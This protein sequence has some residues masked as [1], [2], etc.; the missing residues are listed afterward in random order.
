MNTMLHY[1]ILRGQWLFAAMGAGVVLI[2]AT[3]ATYLA[4][5]RPRDAALRPENGKKSAA[6]FSFLDA[7]P[8]VLILTFAGIAVFM[9]AYFIGK[10]ASPP[11]W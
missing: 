10:I 9:L 2:L 11:N 5:W 4:I 6:F 1:E 7:M 8:A 3:V